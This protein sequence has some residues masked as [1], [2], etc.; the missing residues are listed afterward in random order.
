MRLAKS[1]FSKNV[2]T[3]ATGT[4]VA[5][6]I[7]IIISPILTRLFTP[8]DFGAL[9]LFVSITSVFAAISNGRYELAV[10]LPPGEEDAFNLSVLGVLLNAV[11]SIVLLVVIAWI[12]RDIGRLLGNAEIA[13]WLYLVPL[14]V[15]FL[16]LFN[17]A[18]SFSNRTKQYRDIAAANILKSL[19]LAG[20]QLG[21]GALKFG[22]GGLIS[23]QVLSSALANAKLARNIL[24][25]VNWRAAL[26]WRRIK[27]L[28]W[29]YRDFP[30]YSMPGILANTL[31]LN[32]ASFM[33][34]TYFGAAM[35]GQYAL[36]QRVLGAPA[37]LI[38]GAVGQVFFQQASEAVRRTGSAQPLFRRT[39]LTLI[40]MAIPIFTLAYFIVE[41][42]FELVF[43]TPW[44]I[45][46][47]LAKVMIPLFAVRFIVS[48]LSMMNQVY[49]KN[50]IGLL[51]NL[52]ILFL[53]IAVFW[54][55]RSIAELS[56]VLLGLSFS[57]SVIYLAMLY[58][59]SRYKPLEPTK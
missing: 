18:A 35:L 26:S 31:S 56:S 17:V 27:V 34:S 10:L 4:T 49:L 46:G 20:V 32:V 28:A 13:S 57:L 41:D 50:A 5:Q 51:T 48:P 54:F 16:G 11:L 38:S 25:R 44:R 47:T 40:A 14:T 42:L 55:G 19:I 39:L 23:G 22:V 8:E 52:A 29:Q 12:G 53:T 2:L 6:A 15:F 21:A 3:L 1:A 9:A 7:P 37:T 30:L 24:S 45:A 36:M 58:T 43:G 59:M 33:I